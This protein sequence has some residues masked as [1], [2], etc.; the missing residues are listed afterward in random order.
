M[1][2]NIKF[3]VL[4][5]LTKRVRPVLSTNF[6]THRAIFKCSGPHQPA[7][8][9]SGNGIGRHTR[10]RRR[11]PSPQPQ[12]AIKADAS[13]YIRWSQAPQACPTALSD[14]YSR[15]NYLHK[16][17]LLETD[18]AAGDS[19]ESSGRSRATRRIVRHEPVGPRARRRFVPPPWERR[20]SWRPANR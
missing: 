6:C 20:S 7:N 3:A 4:H 19:M 1:Y 5:R 8:A 16:H 18:K 15:A 13:V 9:R 12:P 2:W 11:R 17:P 10:G 14:S